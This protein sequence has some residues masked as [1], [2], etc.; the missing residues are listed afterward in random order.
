MRET[1]PEE[2]GKD[3]RVVGKDATDPRFPNRTTANLLK[4]IDRAKEDNG[5]YNGQV[6]TFKAG[7]FE[8]IN[9]FFYTLHCIATLAHEG[10]FELFFTY[11]SR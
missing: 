10:S 5:N 1:N 3:E 7:D 6:T 8:K 2:S 9:K 11:H 4:P